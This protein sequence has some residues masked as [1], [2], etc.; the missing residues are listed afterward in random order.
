MNL[1]NLMK[2]KI[3]IISSILV[4]SIAT[5]SAEDNTADLMIEENLYPVEGTLNFK[6]KRALAAALSD[7]ENDKNPVII[8][9]GLIK[10]LKQYKE[11]YDQHN[12]KFFLVFKDQNDPKYVE[13]LG[14]VMSV[15]NSNSDGDKTFNEIPN[16]GFLKEFLEFY[17]PNS[18]HYNELRPQ[19]QA[20]IRATREQFKM[21]S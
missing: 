7:L 14:T 10:E 9:A 6:A 5:L 4:L 12:H 3:I 15:I 19:Q 13:L 16:G 20:M 17:Q 2:N 18:E 21:P 8:R 1:K 11:E